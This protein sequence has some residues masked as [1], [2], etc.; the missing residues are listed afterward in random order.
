MSGFD[1]DYLSQLIH[2]HATEPNESNHLSVRRAELIENI[3]MEQTQKIDIDA[4]DNESDH[5]DMDYLLELIFELVKL[6]FHH[7]PR[8]YFEAFD[9]LLTAKQNQRA[10]RRRATKKRHRK[11]L[12][13]KSTIT[14]FF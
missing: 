10:Q 1:L 13:F 12:S 5:D 6:P 11:H 7:K 3:L 8:M 9:A 4:I 14:P 2:F